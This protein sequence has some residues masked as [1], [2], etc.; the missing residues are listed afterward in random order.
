MTSTLPSGLKSVGLGVVTIFGNLVG[1]FSTSIVGA[2]ID[3]GGYRTALLSMSGITIAATVVVYFAL[4]RKA[5]ST[6]S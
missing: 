4:G 2:L 6:P 1:A 3:A 5:G